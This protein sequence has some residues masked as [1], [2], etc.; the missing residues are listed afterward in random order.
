M[1]AAAP[2]SVLADDQNDFALGL[3]RR[4]GQTP[5][6]LAF[7]PLS[8]L[9]ELAMSCAGARGDTAAQMRTVLR[10]PSA[11]ERVHTALAEMCQTISGAADGA[12]RLAVANS[13]WA[14]DGMALRQAFLDLITTHY[15]GEL[16]RV[17]FLKAAE[18]SA[19]MNRWAEE[20]TNGRIRGLISSNALTPLTRLVLLNAVYFKSRWA[21]PFRI[22][23]T[24]P[25]PFHLAD[26]RTMEVPLMH[27]RD[28]IRYRQA[29]DFH[30]V[31]LEYRGGRVSM[32]VLL[33][34]ENDGL[35]ALEAAISARVHT[36]G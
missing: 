17:D 34:Y 3:Y 19:R 8:V 16:H 1:S 28:R 15:G 7:S 25:A 33:P 26:G 35:P 21:T 20:R 18:A 30:A 5:G 6:N 31:E 27:R 14:Q 23:S 24:Q 10:L 11:D 2:P 12:H 9:V 4:L 22:H 36:H 29:D 13:I 32:L